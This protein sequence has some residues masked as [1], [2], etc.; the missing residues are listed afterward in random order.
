MDATMH[1]GPYTV[2][3]AT[4]VSLQRMLDEAAKLNAAN[5]SS[6][7]RLQIEEVHADFLEVQGDRPAAKILA[8][9][10]F[11]EAVALG[12]NPIAEHAKRLLDDD[13]LLLRWERTYQQMRDE[14]A[15]LKH[16][17]QTDEELTRV[18]TQM[19][20]SMES[21]PARLDVIFELLRSFR[22]MSQERVNWCRHLRIL[23]DLT[24]NRDPKSAYSELPT[25]LGFCD[26][27]R[28]SSRDAST[29]AAAV[30]AEFKRNFCSLCLAR[31][32]KR[33]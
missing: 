9:R 3:S 23:E 11:S 26:K 16:A 29:D 25:R 6:E 21:P 24:A 22:Q 19:L 31:D 18:A 2:E 7:G 33:K 27:F 8:A 1:E 14:D 30:I 13:T 5:G 10:T 28:Y 17:N 15:D 12:I 4:R 32:P 20:R